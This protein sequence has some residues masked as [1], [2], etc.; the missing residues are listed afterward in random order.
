MESIK[1]YLLS[2]INVLLGAVLVLLGYSSCSEKEEDHAYLYGC[3]YAY[4]TVEGAV[5]NREGKP[6]EGKRVIQK[7]IIPDDASFMY[8][9]DTVQTGADGSYLFQDISNVVESVR[10]IVEDPQGAYAPDSVDLML[11]LTDEKKEGWCQGTL[12][13]KA[14]FH[15]KEYLPD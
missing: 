1:K 12:V 2:K 4:Y 7:F 5:Y 11:T 9:P 10:I 14:D 3:P 6:L 8:Y 13:G 15:L